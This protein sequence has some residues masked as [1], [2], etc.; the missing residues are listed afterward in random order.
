MSTLEFGTLENSSD[1][2][3]PEELGRFAQQLAEAS[4]AADSARIKERIAL[5]F[6]GASS[7]AKRVK[8]GRR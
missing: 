4:N 8:G 3:S 2:L 7:I 1:R 5:G 6:Y